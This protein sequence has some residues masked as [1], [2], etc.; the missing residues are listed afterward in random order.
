MFFPLFDDNPHRRLPWV[1]LLLIAVNFGVMVYLAGMPELHRRTVQARYGFVPHRI[2]QLSN[3]QLVIKVNLTPELPPP[4]QHDLALPPIPGQVYASLLTMMFLHGGW[5]HIIGNMWFLW[6]FGNNIEDRLG[7]F[8]F[9]LFYLLGGLAAAATHWVM[10]PMSDVPVIGASGAVAAVLGAYALTFPKAKVRTLLFL[11][12]FIRII[13]LPA[14]VV[15]GMWFVL[16]I[17]EGLVQ[18]GPGMGMEVAWWAH[19]GGFLAGMVLMP[20]LAL[21][22]PPPDADWREEVDRMF[23]LPGR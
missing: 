7:H 2:S 11:G 4:Q 8:L 13:D 23:D 19:V 21:G 20:I 18:L 22:A 12:I 14:L 1:T 16:Q 17:I 15:L 9:P 5:F 6:I 10:Q 3:R